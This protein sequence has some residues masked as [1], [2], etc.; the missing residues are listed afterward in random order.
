MS[1]KRKTQKTQKLEIKTRKPEKKADDIFANLGNKNKTSLYEKHPIAE[2]LQNELDTQFKTNNTPSIEK[3]DTQFKQNNTPTKTNTGYPSDE[4]L[5]IQEVNTGHPVSKKLGV[6]EPSTSKTDLRKNTKTPSLENTG[7]PKNENWKNWEKKRSTVRVNLQLPKEI[8]QKV[9]EYCVKQ[10]RE[11]KELKLKEFYEQAAYYFLDFLGTQGDRKLGAYAPFDDK[12]PMMPINTS[13]N[14]IYQ[15]IAYNKIFNEKTKWK[16]QDDAVA[17][18]YNDTDIR[19]IELGIIS[20]QFNAAFKKIH[21]FKYYQ[22]QIDE[23]LEQELKEDMINFLLE[24]E[25]GKWQK[26]MIDRGLNANLP[27]EIWQRKN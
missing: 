13:L 20:T 7:Y 2:M 18:Q 19:V 5:G 27:Y 3:L 26:A 25:R 8:D 15:Y 6:N 9:R 12:L 24:H 23:Y 21:S 16:P 17:N 10:G 4:I 1:A 14:I 11:G 22:K